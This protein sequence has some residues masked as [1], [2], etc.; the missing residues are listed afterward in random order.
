MGSKLCSNNQEEEKNND[1]KYNNIINDDFNEDDI[2]MGD[3]ISRDMNMKNSLYSDETPINDKKNSNL[4]NNTEKD[5]DSYK[6]NTINNFNINDFNRKK[7]QNRILNLSNDDDNSN[8]LNDNKICFNNEYI[9]KKL[10]TENK[11]LV[12]IYKINNINKII[13]T[14]RKYK[15][16]NDNYI[17]TEKISFKSAKKNQRI[18]DPNQSLLF[19]NIKSINSKTIIIEKKNNFGMKKLKNGSIYFGN[20]INNK[21]TGIGKLITKKGEII[22]G[23]FN[24]NIL[25]NYCILKEE[26]GFFYE[27]EIKENKN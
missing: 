16:E 14:Y 24:N 26:N 27:G 22:K 18:I 15:E 12:N 2:I 9:Y 10:G 13:N 20:I 21:C 19:E 8:I 4:Y 25:E 17:E 7:Q 5:Y 6:I 1:T 23:Y 3:N 11:R